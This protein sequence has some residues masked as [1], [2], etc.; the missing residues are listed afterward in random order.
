MNGAGETMR[1][2]GTLLRSSTLSVCL[3]AASLS[4]AATPTS[5]A[6]KLDKHLQPIA[7]AAERHAEAPLMNQALARQS[8]H[9]NSPLD[10]RWNTAG[11]VQ[12][13]LRLTQGAAGPS[14]QSLQSLGATGIVQNR[15]LGVIQAWLPAASLK[16]AA[17]LP[18]VTRV[19][20]PRYALRRSAPAFRPVAQTGSVDTEGDRILGAEQFRYET[21]ITGSGVTVGVISNGD[22]HISSSQSTGDLPSNIWNDPNDAGG[23]GGFSPASSGDE[24]TAMM[25]IVYDLAP[26]VKQL[27]FCG[28]QTTVDFITCLDDFSSDIGVNIVVDDLAFPGSAMFT[29]DTFTS[30][31]QSFATSNPN[32]R[33]VTATGNDGTAYWQGTWN[34]ES[35]S[36]TVNGVS[37][38]KA[39]NFGLSGMPYLQI[40]VPNGDDIAYI[41]EWS[42]PWDDNATT[43]DTNDYD[44]VVFDN[45][46]SDSSGG[47][48]H[49]AVACNQGMNIG[50]SSGGS[51]C[52]QSNTQGL[53]TPGPQPVQGSVWKATQS[54]YYLEVLQSSGDG[55]PAANLKILVYDVSNPYQISVYPNTP[56]SVY[57]HAALGSPTEISV[58]AINATNALSSDYTIESYSSQGP[59][60]LG[61][62][63]SASESVPKPD[64]VA[65]DCVSVTGAGGFENPFCGTSAAAPHIAGLVA[66]LMQGYPSDSPY[67]LL[68]QAATQPGSS[69]PN[70]TF[71][72]GVPILTNLLQAGNIPVPAP[73]II[74]PSN[75]ATFTVGKDT[76]FNGNCTAN[77]MDP[78]DPINFQYLWNFGSS[79]VATS[80]IEDPQ[81][82]EITFNRPGSY[83]VTL[84]CTDSAG[85]TTTSVN[86][87]VKAAPSSGGG[88]P[89]D[90]LSL[91]ALG[92]LAAL[93]RRAPVTRR[94]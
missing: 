54:T 68:Q 45:S 62:T 53:N 12:V 1:I 25:E 83:T 49:S 52:N 72:Y 70:G 34:P 71:G 10:A 7:D 38:T 46:N 28:P 84:T 78:V 27:G 58:G 76:V 47:V 55:N 60:E 91:L 50:P 18:D 30:G 16:A 24:G 90:L 65:P 31:I 51:L 61:V 93:E 87:T 85:S 80:T 11:Q 14:I 19:S 82:A 88:G 56:G 86:I 79:G 21:G 5:A 36:T 66:L 92:L 32:I 8:A 57:G 4:H 13:Y 22:D 23:S 43:N 20:L 39:N 81:D 77:Q 37:Y 17:D 89:M 35:V 3:L 73:D 29:T 42:D 64:F 75:G 40:T 26:G 6:S 67:T 48:G 33:L 15:E 9:S 63:G 74:S 2:K 41:L 94:H 69:T 44:V 59:V